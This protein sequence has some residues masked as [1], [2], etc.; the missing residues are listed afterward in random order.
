V[1]EKASLINN[2]LKDC[3]EK[4]CQKKK[5]KTRHFIIFKS[6]GGRGLLRMPAYE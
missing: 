2:L 5:K 3:H 6:T 4:K 1:F